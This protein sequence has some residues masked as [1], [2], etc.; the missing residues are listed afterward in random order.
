MN[1]RT[2][3]LNLLVVLRALVEEGSVSRAGQRIGLSQSATSHALAR[4]RLL[5]KDKLLVRSATGM[6]PTPRALRLAVQVRAILEDIEATLAP[7][8]FDPRTETRTFD[9]MVETYE[10]IVIVAGIVDRVSRAAPN[11]DLSIRSASSAAITDEIDKGTADIAIGSFADIGDRFMNCRLLSDR[12]VCVMRAGHPLAAAPMTL[13][14]FLAAPHL[15]VS[16]SGG[17]GD[18]V[19]ATLA[20]A[21]HRRRVALRL[22]NGLAAAVALSRSDLIAVV[23]A[24]AAGMFARAAPLAIVEPP[25]ALPAMNFRLI[26]H[27]RLNDNAA[28]TWLRHTLASLGA[29]ALPTA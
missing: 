17:S 23:S 13:A 10:T 24:G 19:D 6:E 1:L 20:A 28:H 9:V 26:W 11:I 29:A 25:L 27:R 7:D 4:L 12:Y 8:T 5:V 22:P 15:V 21:G 3:D 16:M 2:I 18:L 14:A